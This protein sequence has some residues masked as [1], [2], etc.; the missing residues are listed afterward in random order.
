MF[1]TSFTP[2]EA[3]ILVAANSKAQATAD[4]DPTKR[5]AFDR[6]LARLRNRNGELMMRM[7]RDLNQEA[8][9]TLTELLAVI[10][11]AAVIAGMGVPIVTTV[12]DSYSLVLASQQIV[13]QMQA[14]RMKAVT[15]NETIRVHFFPDSNFYQIETGDGTLLSGP[16]FFAPSV[17]YNGS[18]GLPSVTFPGRYVAFQ[19]N[20]NL[21][22]NGVGGAGRVR[23][24]N[25]SRTCIDILVNANGMVRPTPAYKGDAPPF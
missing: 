25:N 3:T 11:G 2:R 17:N 7:K 21:P 22:T 19:P 24:A 6:V 23:I 9:F 13:T 10:C 4:E 12:T 18:G 16:Y 14:A 20:G 1:V 15:N 5:Q 8:G